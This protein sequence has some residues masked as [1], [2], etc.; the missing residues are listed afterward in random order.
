MKLGPSEDT[1]LWQLPK[2]HPAF[3]DWWYLNESSTTKKKELWGH[4]KQISCRWN[5]V[6]FL[7]DNRTSLLGNLGVRL[8]PHRWQPHQL[9]KER[10]KHQYFPSFAPHQNNHT[11][12]DVGINFPWRNLSSSFMLLFLPCTLLSDSNN[13]HLFFIHFYDCDQSTKKTTL[14]ICQLCTG[15]LWKTS[16]VI[17]LWLSFSHEHVQCSSL[18]SS[19]NILTEF[20]KIM[21]GWISNF[22][23]GSLIKRAIKVT[24]RSSICFF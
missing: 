20:D 17:L 8:Y 23:Q 1:G 24:L 2:V 21:V 13:K 9:I 6:Q 22:C 14:E 15:F 7:A 16:A 3:F 18:Y 19:K 4:Q 5:I 12:L 11:H 10:K